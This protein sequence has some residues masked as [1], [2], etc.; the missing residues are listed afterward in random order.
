MDFQRYAIFV[1]PETGP[2]ANFGAGWLGWDARCGMAATPPTLPDLPLPLDEI[3]QTPRKYGFHGTIKPP[4]RLAPDQ[5]EATLRAALRTF[6]TKTAPVT[7]DALELAQ[8]G[9]F[10][11]LVPV[12]DT[13]DLATLAAKTVRRFDIFRAPLSDAELNRRRQRRLSPR[14]DALLREWGYP[15][16]MEEFRFH[17]TLTG[18]LPKAKATALA[19]LL[20]PVFAPLLPAPFTIASLSLM[21]EDTDGMFRQIDRFPLTGAP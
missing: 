15:Y 19:D 12:G 5:A 2:L 8:L 4:F 9:R 7:L 16:V 1:L 13:R 17:L 10:L 3:T 21:G 6:A 11:A 18:K 14:Q 20:A